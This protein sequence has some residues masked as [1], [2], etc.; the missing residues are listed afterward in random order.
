MKKT[1][2]VFVALAI[3]GLLGTPAMASDIPDGEKIFNKKCKMCHKIDKKKIG[4]AVK[5]MNQ[6]AEVLRSAITNGRKSMP[7]YSGKL[8]AGEIDAVVVYLREKQGNPCAT[9][10]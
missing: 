8:S 2:T 1:G 10:L 3:V 6:D 5:A 4:P 7:K 9:K